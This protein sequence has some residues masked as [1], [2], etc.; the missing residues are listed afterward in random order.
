VFSF[1]RSV[2]DLEFLKSFISDIDQNNDPIAAAKR[3]D[4]VKKKADDLTKKA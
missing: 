3:L 2:A 1:A 4:D